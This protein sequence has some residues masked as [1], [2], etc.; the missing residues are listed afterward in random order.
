MKNKFIK[1]ETSIRKKYE[2][3]GVDDFYKQNKMTY[4]NPHEMKIDILISSFMKNRNKDIKILD[5]CCGSGEITR[6]LIKNGFNN[7][8][9]L[10]PY[11]NKL[12]EEK[13]NK[14]CFNLDF[15]DL[16]NG[17][18]LEKFDIIICSFAL[19]LAEISLLPNILYNLSL[20]SKELIILTP[21]KKP[22]IKDFFELKNETYIDKI[23]LREYKVK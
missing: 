10:D 16:A 12:Y 19:H 13:T 17:K 2:E 9:G 22:E 11:T 21:H 23:R 15:K 5:L 7:I 4:Q 18:L 6:S 8:Q 14:P 3:L 1:Q 20:I